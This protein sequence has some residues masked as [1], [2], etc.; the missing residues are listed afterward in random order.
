MAASSA[1]IVD[2]VFV[3]G[4]LKRGF[5]L[6]HHM[7]QGVFAGTATVQGALCSVGQYPGLVEGAGMVRGEV[8][9]FA[10][11]AIALEVLDEIEEYDPSNPE[12]SEFV[13]RVRPATFDADKRVVQAWCYV[14]NRIR[15]G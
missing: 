2:S 5:S 8:Y 14:Y 12:Q 11:I 3:Y 4:L 6:H 10:D 1:A 9:R 13:R 7:A 15:K